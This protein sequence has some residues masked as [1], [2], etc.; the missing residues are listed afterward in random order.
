MK[1]WPALAALLIL[2]PPL[3]AHA[4]DP[5]GF[6][7]TPWGAARR[8]VVAKLV[9]D[10]CSWSV[11][12]RKPEGDTIACYDYAL[13][14]VGSVLVNLEFVDDQFQRYTIVASNRRLPEFRAWVRQQFGEP[15]TI[16]QLTGEVATWDWPSGATA[17]FRQHCLTSS[18]ACFTLSA[19][20]GRSSPSASRH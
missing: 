8:D 1:A 6:A 12:I 18:E 19:P 20:P 16:M 15:T 14:A 9:K 4:E 3:P 7:D 11:T 10:K 13:G 2:A 5:P 17:L